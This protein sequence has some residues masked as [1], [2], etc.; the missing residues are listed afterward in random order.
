MSIIAHSCDPSKR[1]RYKRYLY[2]KGESTNGKSPCDLEQVQS[3]F[4]LFEHYNQLSSEGLDDEHVHHSGYAIARAVVVDPST[5]SFVLARTA[6][7]VEFG[8]EYGVATSEDIPDDVLEKL[9]KKPLG[10]W[11]M[12]RSSVAPPASTVAGSAA[13]DAA[14]NDPVS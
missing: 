8:K 5:G 12:R 2:T 4:G 1:K 11:K 10:E 3:S 9:S 13:R 6:D 7:R 14:F